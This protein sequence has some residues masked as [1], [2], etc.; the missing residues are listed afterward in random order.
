M[1]KKYSKQIKYLVNHII[2]KVPRA[3]LNLQTKLVKIYYPLIEKNTQWL[4]QDTT[5]NERFYCI[6]NDI[7]ERP[8][9]LYYK[10]KEVV[11]YSYI[12]N[13]FSFC[14]NVCASKS[15]ITKEKQKQTNLER[16][17]FEYN[18]Q[19]PQ[20][21]KNSKQ[22]KL[23][24][25]GDE[26]YCNPKKCKQTKL[27]KYGNE[28]WNNRKKY[29]N[30]CLEKYGVSNVLFLYKGHSKS[31]Q[32]LFWDIYN[33]LPQELQK[34]T[35]FAELNKEFDNHKKYFYDFVISNIKI[36]IEYNGEK[37]HPN[38]NMS[39]EE[40]NIW[41][42]PYENN[43]MNAD[44]KWKYDQTK[45]N[46]LRKRGYKDLE[47]WESKFLKNPKV[48]LKDCLDFIFSLFY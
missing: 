40:W 41:S 11:Y 43:K 5:I 33:K 47:I 21:L 45:L 20:N 13:Y 8:K 14:C 6:L 48:V 34:K 37:F 42:T 22:T 38:P 24:K 3:N 10:E 7:F 28:N 31:S 12:D 30:T 46:I 19:D 36:C 23:E 35:Y 32:K 25:Y 4:S 18:F 29:R 16:S 44:E 17:G 39:T 2:K 27:E 26:N 1:I 15:K 9:C